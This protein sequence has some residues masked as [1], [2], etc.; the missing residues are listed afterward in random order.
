MARK[1]YRWYLLLRHMGWPKMST[2]LSFC[3]KM[4]HMGSDVAIL[5]HPI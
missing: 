3:D 4:D 1:F 2:C 5:V